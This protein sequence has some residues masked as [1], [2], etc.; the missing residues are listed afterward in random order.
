MFN[1]IVFWIVAL[2]STAC[3]LTL[4]IK[5]RTNSVI[6]WI[7]ST[8]MLA[9]AALPYVFAD[10]LITIGATIGFAVGAMLFIASLYGKIRRAVSTKTNQRGESQSKTISDIL[11]VAASR[12]SLI[13]L[14]NYSLDRFLEVF[15]LNS[16]AIHIFHG[17]KNMLVMG[18][19]RGLIPTH[20]NRLE[21]IKPG[22]T[23]IGRAVQNRRVLIIRDLSVS[24][25]YSFFGGK[26]EGYSFLAVAPIMVDEKCWGVITLL[27]R[28]KYQ[29]GMLD[30]SQLEQFGHKLGQA[31][32]LGRENRR[33]QAAFNRLSGIVKFYNHLFGAI[34]E[35]VSK[36]SGLDDKN[37]FHTLRNY[38][39]TLFDGKPFGVIKLT[40]GTCR[41][42]YLQGQNGEDGNLPEGY[43]EEIS[44]AN[45]PSRFQAGKAFYIEQPELAELIP[46][47]LFRNSD[48]TGFGY[49]FGNG[50]SAI[51]VVD[52]PEIST[53]ENYMDD[54]LFIGNLLTLSYIGN[55]KPVVK[56]EASKPYIAKPSENV[57]DEVT[58]D[59]STIFAGISGNVQLMFDQLGLNG[60]TANPDDYSRWL[61]SIEEAALKGIG[62]LNKIGTRNNPNTIIQSVLDSENLNV[63]FYPGSKIPQV[64]SNQ[65]EFEKTVKAILLEAIADNRL[66]RLKTTPQ[67][68]KLAI[69]IEGQVKKG[70]PSDNIIGLAQRQNIELNLVSQDDVTG[71]IIDRFPVDNDKKSNLKALTIEN[72]PVIT[73]LLEEFFRQIG[74]TNHTVATGKEGLAYIESATDR[75]ERIDVAVIDMTLD[76]ISG[77]ELCRKIKETNSGIYTV[78]ISSWGVNLYKNTLDDA[79]VDAVLHKPFRLEQ[80]NNVLPKKEITDAAE[81]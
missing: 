33:M 10:Q 28:K 43:H 12:D 40:S 55:I 60:E 80:L 25:D 1:F 54:V 31:L 14:L 11:Q 68:S 9:S 66:I 38:P 3:L 74:Y 30:V 73:D 65:D 81:N 36:Q 62:H 70:F 49:S 69:T 52:I 48:V 34:R 16:G 67:N 39:A 19:F 20:A 2:S 50:F 21:L 24:P 37:I 13:E 42:V 78:I 59:L 27:G 5:F 64:K 22:D 61:N 72:K 56:P 75:N 71:E 47:K 77:L 23:A 15:S 29:R 76:D 46:L 17:S 79:G 8:L 7:G 26:T 35:D 57:I 41:C 51:L 32:V 44:L 45:L 58:Q 18:A 63:A 6:G 53:L 4:S